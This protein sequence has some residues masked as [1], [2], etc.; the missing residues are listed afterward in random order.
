MD[1]NAE[2]ARR[3]FVESLAVSEKYEARYDHARTRLAQA[4]AGLKFGWPGSAEQAA[5]ARV[6]V[7]HLENVEGN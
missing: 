4:E 2:Q 7:T 6:V 5:E 3:S 1:G